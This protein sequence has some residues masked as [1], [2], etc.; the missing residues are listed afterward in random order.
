MSTQASGGKRQTA[1]KNLRKSSWQPPTWRVRLFLI[2]TRCCRVM[3]VKWEENMARLH[4]QQCSV[5]NWCVMVVCTTTVVNRNK[6]NKSPKLN[7]AAFQIPT[8]HKDS[9]III[10][11]SKQKNIQASGCDLIGRDEAGHR[12]HQRCDQRCHLVRPAAPKAVQWAADDAA[13]KPASRV[14][15]TAPPAV[16]ALMTNKNKDSVSHGAAGSLLQTGAQWHDTH[17]RVQASLVVHLALSLSPNT[18]WS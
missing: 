3:R 16:N 7:Y 17:T 9:N 6:N 2:Q 1:G 15:L 18:R 8:N 14:L 12:Y 11:V 5:G 4:F 13:D 10:N